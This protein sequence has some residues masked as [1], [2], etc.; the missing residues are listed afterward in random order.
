M[1]N[2]VDWTQL[3]EEQWMLEEITDDQLGNDETYPGLS[4]ALKALFTSKPTHLRMVPYIIRRLPVHQLVTPILKVNGER[5]HPRTHPQNAISLTTVLLGHHVVVEASIRALVD[6]IYDRG[7]NTH[8][9]ALINT[10]AKLFLRDSDALL[11]YLLEYTRIP[12][13]VVVHAFFENLTSNNHTTGSISHYTLDVLED[14]LSSIL[15]LHLLYCHIPSGYAS[16]VSVTERLLGWVSPAYELSMRRVATPMDTGV[17]ILNL[18]CIHNDVATVRLI[19]PL[20]TQ[21]EIEQQDD[22]GQTILFTCMSL[23]NGVDLL[24]TICDA[25]SRKFRF[26]RDRDGRTALDFFNRF[27]RY[28]TTSRVSAVYIQMLSPSVKKA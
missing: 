9:E 24:T 15:A 1:A 27:T 7:S 28:S 3:G 26:L 13:K 21:E 18:A 10:A 20:L 12:R 5:P 4:F 23:D 8:I 16:R 22:A 14:Y 6:A 19:L 11:H 17:P 25:T 2:T